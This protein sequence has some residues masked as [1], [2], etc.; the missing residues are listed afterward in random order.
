MR[1]DIQLLPAIVTV[2]AFVAYVLFKDYG[3]SLWLGVLLGMSAAGGIMWGV[4][5]ALTRL[6]RGASTQFDP[7][8][9]AVFALP[10]EEAKR[11]ALE[12]MSDPKRFQSEPAAADEVSRRTIELDRLAPEVRHVLSRFSKAQPVNADLSIGL[13]HLSQALSDGELVR[14]GKDTEA[15]VAVRPGREQVLIMAPDTTSPDDADSYPSVYHYVLFND[16]LLSNEVGPR[17]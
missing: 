2:G 15:E 10:L 4:L 17:A 14:V 8:R 6:N 7:L 5:E 16:A 9:K 13:K 1:R 12:I 3:V 11:R